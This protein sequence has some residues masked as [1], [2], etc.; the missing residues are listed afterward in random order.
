MLNASEDLYRKLDVSDEWQQGDIVK[1]LYV[2]R[3]LEDDMIIRRSQNQ[4]L[5]YAKISYVSQLAEQNDEV[6]A[7]F[8]N[9]LSREYAVI[10]VFKTDVMIVSQTCDIAHDEQITV[11]GVCS[12]NPSDNPE[13]QENI[14]RG[15]VMNAFYLPDYPAENEESFSNLAKLTVLG[16]KLLETHKAQR[17]ISLTPKGLRLFQAFIERFFGREAMPEDIIRIITE[18]YRKLHETELRDKIERVY[19]DHSKEQ[20]SLLVALNKE[21]NSAQ[22]FVETARKFASDSVEHNYE[23]KVMYQLLDN[24]SLRDIEGFREFR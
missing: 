2:T 22:A 21:D 7:P 5:P 6:K 20:I 11:A 13:L 12:F 9:R 4:D 17:E 14:R 19:Y 8:S 18:F 15:N 23:L 10:P 3:I 1:G 24:I 16:K